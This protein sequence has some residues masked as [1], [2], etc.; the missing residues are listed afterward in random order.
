MHD[1]I[2]RVYPDIEYLHSRDENDRLQYFSE[3]VI[4]AAWNI[5]VDAINDII[6]TR[7]CGDEKNYLSAD[8]AFQDDGILDPNVPQE[9]LNTINLPGMSLHNIT[10]KIGCPIILLRNLE[11]AAGLCNGTRMIVTNLK[12]R[13][14]EAMILMGSH[15]G[16]RTFIPRIVLDISASSG[17]PFTLRRRQFPFHGAFSMTINKSQGQSLRILDFISSLQSLHMV[18]YRECYQRVSKKVLSEREP[19]S[20]NQIANAKK[21][22]SNPNRFFPNTRDTV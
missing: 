9:Y 17:L 11:R 14:I 19:P 18:N 22:S 15:A 8:N 1:L 10:L 13:V 16:K 4:L 12:E 7:L 3:R 21:W 5:D 2:D 6:L 20:I